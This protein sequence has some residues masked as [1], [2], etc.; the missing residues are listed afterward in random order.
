MNNLISAGF[1]L[2]R[3]EEPD[4]RIKDKYTS[5]EIVPENYKIK[6]MKFVPRT[7]IFKAR[8]I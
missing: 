4:Q 1:I 5:K 8:K 6:A 3:I 7:I 2:E